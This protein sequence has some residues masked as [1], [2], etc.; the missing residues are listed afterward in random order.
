MRGNTARDSRGALVCDYCG[1]PTTWFDAQS[2]PACRRGHGCA[3][4]PEAHTRCFV[5]PSG[6]ARTRYLHRGEWLS[7]AQL[8][9]RFGVDFHCLLRRLE[10]GWAVQDAV[11]A[12]VDTVAS[13]A[14]ALGIAARTLRNRARAMDASEREPARRGRPPRVV[15][16]RGES[17]SIHEWTARLALSRAALYRLAAREHGSV[18]RAIERVLRDRAANARPVGYTPRA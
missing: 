18:E 9:R 11:R 12:Q 8:A 2:S 4:R 17:R 14:R 13:R 5:L 15:T 3:R 6:R 1:R 10:R 7:A 16:V